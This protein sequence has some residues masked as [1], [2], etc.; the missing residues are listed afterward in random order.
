[1]SQNQMA[2]TSRYNQDDRN[3]CVFDIFSHDLTCELYLL[4]P[5]QRQNLEALDDF[6]Q[7]VK[8]ESWVK[9]FEMSGEVWDFSDEVVE[10]TEVAIITCNDWDSLNKNKGVW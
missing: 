6:M 10:A 2:L 7:E 4:P 1:M 8:A 9:E 3:D 5:H